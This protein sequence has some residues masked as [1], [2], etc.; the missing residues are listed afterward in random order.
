MGDVQQVVPELLDELVGTGAEQ[1]V[2]VA[3]FVDGRPIVDAVAGVADPTSG[4]PVRPD[5]VFRPPTHPG[6]APRAA[7]V[8]RGAD[9]R[10]P[11]GG[12]GQRPALL[13]EIDRPL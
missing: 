12:A 2:Q 5:T 1:G 11:D 8:P 6:G 4:R 10:V 7:D 9:G 3:A 13:G